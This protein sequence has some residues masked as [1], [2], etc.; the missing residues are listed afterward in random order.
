M[1]N[2]CIGESGSGVAKEKIE[3]EKGSKSIYLSKGTKLLQ[4]REEREATHM[5]YG[6]KPFAERRAREL[7]EAL[8]FGARHGGL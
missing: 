8:A 3:R 5:Y 4:Q 1:E 2:R 6:Q 7:L